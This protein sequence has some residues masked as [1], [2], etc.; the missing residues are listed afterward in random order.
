MRELVIYREL[1]NRIQARLNCMKKDVQDENTRSWTEKHEEAIEAL[2]NFLPHGSGIDSGIS[3]DLINSTGEKIIID[4]SYHAMN[5]G[6][7]YDR[8]IDFS[9]TVTP[10]LIHGISLK[11]TGRFGKYQDIREYL[12][13][14]FDTSLRDTVKEFYCSDCDQLVYARIS[15]ND[16]KC[17]NCDKEMK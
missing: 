1:A 13:D 12:Y 3:I 6:G 7:Y 5:D 15:M 14:I 16:L 2:R 4:S 10:S 8:W 9:I 11:I 17:P